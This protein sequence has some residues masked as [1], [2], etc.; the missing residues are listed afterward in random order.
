MPEEYAALTMPGPPV[1]RMVAMPGCFISAPV[2]SMDGC[3]IHCTQ[4]SGAPASIAASRTIFAAATDDFWAPG[5]K[6]NT[7]GQRVLSASSDLKMA[8]EVGLVTGVTPATTPTGSATSS[9]PMTSS[10]RIRPTVFCPA[11]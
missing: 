11:M 8:V 1:A 9:M 3:S 7:I 4:F 10:S 6:P 2:A 5:W